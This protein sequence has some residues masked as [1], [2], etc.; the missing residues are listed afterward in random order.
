MLL[1]P[2]SRT[3]EENFFRKRP[4]SKPESTHDDEHVES[5]NEYPSNNATELPS[6]SMDEQSMAAPVKKKLK[7]NRR[8]RRGEKG[9]SIKNKDSS[10]K[11]SIFLSNI[12]GVGSK[13]LSLQAIVNNPVVDPEVICLVETNLKKTS[14]INLDGYKVSVKTAKKEIWVVLL[15]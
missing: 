9:K 12:R 13:Q 10:N 1:P 2:S 4:E 8:R 11:F 6:K 5:P 7:N 14:K 15:C 3:D